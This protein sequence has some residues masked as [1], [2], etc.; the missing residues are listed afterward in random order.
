MNELVENVLLQSLVVILHSV[1][2]PHPQGVGTVRQHHRHNL[3][4][5]VQQ[6]ATMDMGNRN[7]ASV[8]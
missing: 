8:P 4:L 5:I 3:V 7:S 2:L 1:G 6:V